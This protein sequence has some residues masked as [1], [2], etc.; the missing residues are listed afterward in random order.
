MNSARL[1]VLS[2]LGIALILAPAVAQAQKAPPICDRVRVMA[3]AGLEKELIG[4]TVAGSNVSRHEGFVTLAE[5][6]EA[7]KAGEWSE[8]KVEN[9]KVYRWL[10]FEQPKAASVRHGPHAPDVPAQRPQRAP[11]RCGGAG[12]PARIGV[13]GPP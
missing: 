2:L 7:P 4:A 5:I 12:D 3:V 10:R 9:S 6:K 11:H 13:A 8:I 1:F